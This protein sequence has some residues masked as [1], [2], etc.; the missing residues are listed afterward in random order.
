MQRSKPHK[1]KQKKHV[2]KTETCILIFDREIQLQ[3]VNAIGFVKYKL[4]VYESR[5]MRCE[6]AQD[7]TI[8]RSTVRI[9]R[10]ACI[11]ERQA[12]I[13]NLRRLRH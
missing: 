2:V 9:N 4:R 13:I 10:A 6:T 5:P 12:I 1:Q 8:R 11:V 7:S 3:Q